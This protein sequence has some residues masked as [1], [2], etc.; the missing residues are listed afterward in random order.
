MKIALLSFWFPEYSIQLANALSKKVELYLFLPDRHIQYYDTCISSTVRRVPYMLPRMR[1]LLPN[2]RML[3][4][5]TGQLNALSP[6][7]VHLQA[8]YPWFNLIMPHVHKKYPFV[9]TVHDIDTH[10]GDKDSEKFFFKDLAIRHSDRFIVHGNKLKQ[11]FTRKYKVP[12]DRVDSI[13]HGAYSIY[14]SYAP[15][16]IE[17]DDSCVLFFGRIFDYKGLEYLIRAEPFI[18]RAVP[19]LKII[20]AGRGDHFDKYD[21]WIVNRE[22]YTILNRYIDNRETAELFQ[23]ARVVVLPYIEASQSGIIPLAYA[24]GKPVVATDVGSLAEVVDDGRTGFIVPPKDV[25][26][27]SRAV[28]TLLKDQDLWKRMTYFIRERVRN[29]LNWDNIA[30]ATIDTYK[31]TLNM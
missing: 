18:S 25:D 1:S 30:D 10:P 4:N 20:V 7:L 24:F 14:S 3:G 23:K 8:G 15:E 21:K 19:G 17:E 5:I 9:T 12:G 22:K 16:R 28:I 26:R 27:L 2:V 13:H 6:T 29:E 11:A 31:K